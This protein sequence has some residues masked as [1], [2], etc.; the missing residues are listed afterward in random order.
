MIA[1]RGVRVLQ[2]KR[3]ER[4]DLR[5]ETDIHHPVRIAMTYTV[6]NEDRKCTCVVQ[7]K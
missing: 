3:H 1:V 7:R 2:S 4:V 6:D 5:S